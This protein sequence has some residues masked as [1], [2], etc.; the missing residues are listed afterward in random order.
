MATADQIQ[1]LLGKMA[2]EREALLAEA[3]RLGDEAAAFAPAH[4][5][6][7]AQWSPKEQLA[8]LAEMETAYRAWVERALEEDGADV[9][10]VRGKRPRI[11]LTEAHAHGVDEL[12]GQLREQRATTVRLIES[13]APEQFERTA[14]QP[15]FGRL[16][17]MQWLRSYYRHDRMHRDQIAGREPS[18]RPK[19]IGGTEPDQRRGPRV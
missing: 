7:E 19:F 5:E 15:M 16:T 18:Y 1:E 10:A 17:V 13:L 11:A 6:G 14:T 3:Q 2:D 8:H 4:A 12:I 9:S